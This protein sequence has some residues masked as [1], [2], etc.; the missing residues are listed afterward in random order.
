VAAV[1]SLVDVSAG[2]ALHAEWPRAAA[3]SDGPANRRAHERP[4]R[5]VT[6]AAAALSFVDWEVMIR[7]HRRRERRLP[8][9]ARARPELEAAEH[10]VGSRRIPQLL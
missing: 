4:L 3:I 7:A 8:V 9:K 10:A 2:G 6:G 1:G 5:W